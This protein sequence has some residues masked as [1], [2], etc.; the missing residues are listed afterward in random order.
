[1]TNTEFI[2][3]ASYV[4]SVEGNKIRLRSPFNKNTEYTGTAKRIAK[5]KFTTDYSIAFNEQNLM[6]QI[7]MKNN[8]QIDYDIEDMRHIFEQMKPI[9]TAMMLYKDKSKKPVIHGDTIVNERNQQVYIAKVDKQGYKLIQ[10]VDDNDYNEYNCDAQ[11][12]QRL[13]R[14]GTYEYLP[15]KY[16]NWKLDKMFKNTTE[17]SDNK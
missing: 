7:N 16:K 4:V 12:M 9:R 2:I 1:M 6:K 8:Q 3:D 5:E 10:A 13:T 14:F 11:H 15:A 17:G